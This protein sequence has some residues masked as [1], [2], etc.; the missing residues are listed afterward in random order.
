MEVDFILVDGTATEILS[1]SLNSILSVS[2][3]DFPFLI[4][5]SGVLMF[6]ETPNSEPSGVVNSVVGTST[7]VTVSLISILISVVPFGDFPFLILISGVLISVVGTSTLEGISTEML[8]SNLIS[9][10]EVALIP[11]FGISGFLISTVGISTSTDG[12]PTSTVLICSSIVCFD[13]VLISTLGTV[14]DGMSTVTFSLMSILIS[15]VPFGDFPFLILI[16]GVVISVVGTSTLGTFTEGISTEMLSSNLISNSE[17]ALIPAFGISGFLI[18]TVG[19]STSTDGDPTSTVL[20][21]SSIVCFDGVLISTLGTV[22]DG[23]S[24]VTFSFM[25]ILISV[26]PFGDFP[27]WILIS[28]VLISVIG[29]ST[30][31]GIST[32]M[33]SSNL[34]PNSEVALIPAFGISVFLISTVGISTSTDCNPTSTVLIC[35]SIVCFDGVLISTLGTVTDGMSTVTFSLMSILISVVPFGT[36]TEG[37]STEML[38]SNL[39]SNSEVGLDFLSFLPLNP[40]I[41]MSDKSNLVDLVSTFG[42]LMS[43]FVAFTSGTSTGALIPAFGISGFLISTVGISTS[44][45]GDPTSTVLI[46]SSI[47]C[48]DGVLISTLGTVTDGMSTVTF[49]LMSILISVV[50]FGDFP[51]LILISGVL[52][53]VVGTSTLGTFTEGISSEMLSSNLISNS[54]VGLDFLSFLPLNPGILMSDK[55]NLVVLVSTLG[56]LMSCLVAFTP[57]SLTD[58]KSVSFIV[59]GNSAPDIV[60]VMISTLGIDTERPSPDSLL[61]SSIGSSTISSITFS[62]PSTV[63]IRFIIFRIF[64]IVRVVTVW[65]LLTSTLSTSNGSSTSSSITVSLPSTITILRI[66][67]PSSKWND[68][69]ES[70]ISS[71]LG[72]S[73]VSS[74]TD[75]FPSTITF[76]L[77]ILRIFVVVTLSLVFFTLSLSTERR[78]IFSISSGSI[79]FST[80]SSPFLMV[81]LV[82]LLTGAPASGSSIIS[83]TSHSIPSMVMMR[84]ITFLDFHVVAVPAYRFQKYQIPHNFEARLIYLLLRAFSNVRPLRDIQVQNCHQLLFFRPILA[85]LYHP[86]LSIFYSSWMMKFL[87]LYAIY[88]RMTVN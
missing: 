64:L 1:L 6:V 59:L 2:F 81:F 16:S 45:D 11:A 83:S 73:I 32:E 65:G 57:G 10:S 22:T 27:F 17:V 70:R 15:V 19:I 41:L 9:N 74:T 30:L 20:I 24:T 50:P 52:I 76:R 34:T 69:F 82:I 66:L 61:S 29:T 60:V 62:F 42:T 68:L 21:C 49:S 23:M 84:L 58:G 63:F 77:T 75:S 80:I 39:I 25:S 37:I 78:K 56:I 8:S 88:L 3:G 18:S 86:C 47:V 7:L 71:L 26:V 67:L 13:G 35:S 54:E 44:T 38:S 55:S 12:N 33:L 43:T 85:L 46:C 79:I 5:M 72:S 36:F 31:E 40:G 87:D 28:G 14:T 51:F 4:S 53:S 48:F